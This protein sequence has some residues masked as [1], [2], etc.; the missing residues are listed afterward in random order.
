MKRNVTIRGETKR[1]ESNRREAEIVRGESKR[2]EIFA[3]FGL[4]SNRNETTWKAS[5]PP[6]KAP[7]APDG[8]V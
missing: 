2:R 5:H 4:V 1:I 3:Q 7:P 6:D 8:G